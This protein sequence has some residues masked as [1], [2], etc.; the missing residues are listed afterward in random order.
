MYLTSTFLLEDIFKLIVKNFGTNECQKIT[1]SSF[2]SC[3]DDDE[4]TVSF[5]KNSDSAT[6]CIYDHKLVAVC[7]SSVKPVYMPTQKVTGEFLEGE[8]SVSMPSRSA[9]KIMAFILKNIPA[10]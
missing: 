9:N 3:G 1:G 5:R 6:L 4:V 2:I 8:L 7:N 10:K